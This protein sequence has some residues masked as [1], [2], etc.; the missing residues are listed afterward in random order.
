MHVRV[1]L[2]NLKKGE[3][4]EDIHMDEKI[5]LKWIAKQLDGRDGLDTPCSG[6]GQE[7]GSRKQG[8]EPSRS[9]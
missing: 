8:N 2:E 7:V 6:Q 5:V 9:V 3:H 4:L 1:L